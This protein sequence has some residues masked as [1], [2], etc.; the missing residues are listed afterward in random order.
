MNLGGDKGPNMGTT[1]NKIAC[2]T[3][4]LK[5]NSA[6]YILF[7]IMVEVICADNC[8]EKRVLL[9]KLSTIY[10]LFVMSYTCVTPV[11]C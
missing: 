2:A 5:L 7:K 6:S 8:H 10:Q 9:L 4:G 11:F 3:N 1:I